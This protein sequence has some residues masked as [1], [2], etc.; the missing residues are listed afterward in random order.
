MRIT[1]YDFGTIDVDGKTYTSDVIITPDKVKDGWWR[2]EGHHLHPQDLN[3]AIAA[4]PEVIIVGTGYF[5]RMVVHDDAKRY[6][7][8]LGIEL[9]EAETSEAVKAFNELQRTSARVVAAL[10]LTC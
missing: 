9:R 8:G 3:E 10:H 6:L 5:G 2:E 1:G 7:K 4:R